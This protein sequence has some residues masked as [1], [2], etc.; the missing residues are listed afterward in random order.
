MM[1]SRRNVFKATAKAMEMPP[2][3]AA[4]PQLRSLAISSYSAADGSTSLSMV[5]CMPM[6]MREP[7]ATQT[8]YTGR[9]KACTTAPD[10][11]MDSATMFSPPN[12]PAAG[13]ASTMI[14]CCSSYGVMA[15]TSLPCA[16]I[17]ICPRRKKRSTPRMSSPSVS[18][19]YTEPASEP[20]TMNP[21]E[22]YPQASKM[23]T[24]TFPACRARRLFPAW[25][26]TRSLAIPESS[27]IP[28]PS[29]ENSATTPMVS[30]PDVLEMSS[31]RMFSAFPASMR[32][33]PNR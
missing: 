10:A 19:L 3:M 9:V 22:M 33:S 7:A 1:Q 8:R 29:T 20:P 24:E 4:A 21:V 26:S 12:R 2:V 27:T 23:P 6:R 28:A 18:L 13:L 16:R 30:R 17:A 5:Q 11:R 25:S 32:T 14:C 31:S 15:S